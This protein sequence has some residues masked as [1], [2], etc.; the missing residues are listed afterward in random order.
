VQPW[1]ISYLVAVLLA[2]QVAP[3]H[4]AEDLSV[5]AER[6]G[7]RVEVRA[8]ALVAAPATVVWEVL[9][10]YEHLPRFI[11]GI[12]KSV[13]R[14]RDGGR[15]LIEQ[16]GKARFLIF[17]FP[18][19][20][21]LEVTERPPQS[22]SSRAVAGNVRRMT[23]RY[24]I[25]PDAEHGTVLLR[26]VGEIEPDF[27]L[28]PLIGVAALRSSATEQFTAMVAEIERRAGEAPK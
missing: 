8:R 26:Y 9:T 14:S 18:I 16:S 27:K 21:R 23:G 24:E 1:S 20:V 11:P 4:A 28:P 19:E 12:A 13:V 10:D 17:S 6:R 7:E 22:I 3:G 2:V 5:E 15:L 25:Q